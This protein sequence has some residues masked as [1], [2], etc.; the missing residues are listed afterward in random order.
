[1]DV[2][3][4]AMLEVAEEALALEVQD[5]EL[6]FAVAGVLEDRA[7]A[8]VFFRGVDDIPALVDRQA[9][10]HFD[11]GVLAELHRADGH[12]LVPFPGCGDVD[13]VDVIPGDHFFPGVLVAAVDGRRLARLLAD[14]FRLRLGAIIKDVADR[15]DFHEGR[16]HSRGDVGAATIEADDAHANLLHG[17][18]REIPDGFIAGRPRADRAD[19]GGGPTHH[20]GGI[21][22]RFSRRNRT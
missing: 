5:E 15:D 16:R 3:A 6:F 11:E 22:L 19:I 13:D 4:L 2:G 8:L 7:V 10:V 21:R 14:D 9:A 12:R 18:G 20:L 1:M 17:L